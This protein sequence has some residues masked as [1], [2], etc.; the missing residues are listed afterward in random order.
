MAGKLKSFVPNTSSNNTITTIVASFTADDTD[1]SFDELEIP[2][3]AGHITNVYF[4]PGTTAPENLFDITLDW[5]GIDLLG[6]AGANIATAANALISPQDT[7]QNV[8][9]A[10]FA[11]PFTIKPVNSTTNSATFTLII[12]IAI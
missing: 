5:N 4:I 9:Y 12:V 10:G 8:V 3:Y 1:G 6:G 11:G 7:A 2:G